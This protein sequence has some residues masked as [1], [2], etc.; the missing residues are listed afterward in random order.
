MDLSITDI[1]GTL[2]LCSR[3]TFNDFA[4]QAEMVAVKTSIDVENILWIFYNCLSCT[5]YCI[6][7]IRHV[8]VSYCYLIT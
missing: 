3:L 5:P 6:V 7:M 1:A 8:D 2:V 4:V